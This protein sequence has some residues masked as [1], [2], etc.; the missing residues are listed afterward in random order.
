MNKFLLI[1]FGDWPKFRLSKNPPKDKP[2]EIDF[3]SE[4]PINFEEA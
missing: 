1:C 3:I 4:N 2:A